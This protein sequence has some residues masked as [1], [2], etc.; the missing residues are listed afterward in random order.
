MS[1][2]K[3][4]IAAQRDALQAENDR[5]KGELAE[6]RAARGAASDARV[7]LTGRPE[8]RGGTKLSEGERQ[9]LATEG[10]ITDASNGAPLLASDYGVEVVT[11]AGRARLAEFQNRREEH[12]SAIRGVDYVYPSIEPGRLDPTAAVRGAQPAI[13]YGQPVAEPDAK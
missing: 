5:L 10:V 13:A 2:T 1:E 8:F 7:V 4:D 6:A 3:D 11:E 9:A 12:R